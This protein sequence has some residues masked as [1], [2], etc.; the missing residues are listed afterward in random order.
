VSSGHDYN[1]HALYVH[2]PHRVD[3]V[4]TQTGDVLMSYAKPVGVFVGY[5]T[6]CPS[7]RCNDALTRDHTDGNAMLIHISGKEYVLIGSKVERFQAVSDIEHFVSLLGP[8]DVSYPYAIDRS[9]NIYLFLY[10]AV[11]G[12][13]VERQTQAIMPPTGDPYA[14]FHRQQEDCSWAMCDGDRETI[15]IKWSWNAVAAYH[16]L[17]EVWQMS[18][19]ARVNAVGMFCTLDEFAD[20]QDRIAEELG[21]VSLLAYLCLFP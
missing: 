21:L 5:T 1:K 8:N 6:P 16:R 14:W 15:A 12:A 17:A 19:N 11:L 3:V 9:G 2:D 10:K 7:A 20:I 18:G 13:R 4:L